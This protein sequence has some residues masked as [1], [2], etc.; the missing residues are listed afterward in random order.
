MDTQACELATHGTERAGG[1]EDPQP[2]E[3]L[4]AFL[5]GG[6][7]GGIEPGQVVAQAC[8]PLRQLH[9]DGLGV[10]QL[11][12]RRTEARAS[13]LLCR[14]PKS[15]ALSRPLPA[16]SA[17]TLVSAGQA[18]G[19]RFQALHPGV[20]IKAQLTTEAAVDD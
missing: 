18:G 8:S 4:S 6:L 10:S 16:G 5:Q 3:S 7:R 14:R 1:S 13:M 2:H 9:Q 17:P 12:F 11:E 20:G 15:D 19:H